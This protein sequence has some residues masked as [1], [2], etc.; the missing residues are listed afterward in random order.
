MPLRDHFHSPLKELRYWEGFHALWASRVAVAVVCTQTTANDRRRGAPTV[1]VFDG[2]T[3]RVFLQWN[4]VPAGSP[5]SD[6]RP[7]PRQG[8]PSGCSVP[9]TMKL[10]KWPQVPTSALAFSVTALARCQ[11]C[12]TNVSF[13]KR[14]PN[15]IFSS[16]RIAASLW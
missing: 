8:G 4:T 9:G 15:L 14:M 16:H 12:R 5:G 13:S 7:R 3:Q 1:I 2:M 11:L 6:Y 10:T